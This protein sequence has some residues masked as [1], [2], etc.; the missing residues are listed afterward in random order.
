[1]PDRD[2]GNE[3]LSS[4]DLGSEDLGSEDLA[5]ERDPM[6]LLV[7]EFT[8]R[9]RAGEAVDVEEFAAA[10]PAHEA[11]LRGLLPMLQS[12]EQVKRERESSG[13]LVARVSLPEMHRLGDFRIV[14]EVGRGGMGVVFEAFQ[15]SLS[16]RVALKVM[17]QATLLTGNQLMRFQREAQVA[18]QLHHSNIVPVFG[19]G[20]TDGYHWY[21]MQFIEGR[22]LDQWRADEAAKDAAPTGTAAWRDRGRF[23]AR[24][25][26]QVAA[27]L[28]HAHVQGTLHR[29][30]KPA[31]LLLD[32]NDH[33]WVTDF[34]LAKALEAEGLTQSGDLLGTLQYMAPEQFAGL[35][36]A[37]S[38][39]YALGVTLYEL[40][41]LQSAFVGQS[42]S[43]LMAAIRDG[44]PASIRRLCPEA[45]AD[46][47]TIVEKS[48]ASDPGDRYVSADALEQ[49]LEAFLEDRPIAARRQSAMGQVVRWCRRNRAVAAL[50]AATL[51]AVVAAG[52]TGWAAYVV[53][54]DALSTAETANEQTRAQRHRAEANLRHALSAFEG[55]FDALVGRD[56]LLLFEADPDT[57]E[58]YV[59]VQRNVSDQDLALLAGMLEF[60]DN[61]AAQNAESQS[62][63]FETARAYRRVGVIHAR[64]GKLDEAA[65]AYDQALLRYRDVTDRDVTREL[66]AVHLEYG[67]LEQRRWN[68][69][70][71]GQR[72]GLALKLLDR[73]PGGG[74]AM[75]LR[76]ERAQAHFLIARNVRAPRRDGRRSR[77]DRGDRPG[78]GERPDRETRPDRLT[79][80]ERRAE[81]QKRLEASRRHLAHAQ[82]ILEGLPTAYRQKLDVRAFE[83]RCLLLASRFE[84]DSAAAARLGQEGIELLREVTADNPD[85]THVR[86]EL[87]ETLLDRVARARM[88]RSGDGDADRLTLMREARDHAERL[89]RDQP[90]RDHRSLRARVGADLGGELVR[91]ADRVDESEPAG[92]AAAAELRTEAEAEL[93]DATRDPELLPRRTLMAA[94]LLDAL[95][96]RSGRITEA[97]AE[98]DRVFPAVRRVFE[99]LRGE[100]WRWRPPGRGSGRSGPGGERSGPDG[101]R[102]GPRGD[103]PMRGGPPRDG[104]GGPGGREGRRGSGRRGSGRAPATRPSREFERRMRDLFESLPRPTG[105]GDGRSGP[106]GE[107]RGR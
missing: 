20:E 71:A 86:F 40:L 12:L 93:R 91:A 78:P 79:R 38:E 68:P 37:R 16:R 50:I 53:T 102:E 15:E 90:D 70:A 19:S 4:E 106:D 97:D 59:V 17:P 69:D 75:A 73:E 2:A 80:E 36:D 11:E 55:V 31:N 76:F 23:V 14:V 13:G 44:R 41:T 25:G 48:I 84:R 9:L 72:F 10:H 77:G 98:L 24:V 81:Q 74:D 85:A 32:E 58:E 6:D 92:A 107:R 52:I 60:Y 39:V 104:A 51:V 28:H 64:L 103:P 1:M 63:R 87:C 22:G 96:R 67:Q 88:R 94:G 43:E 35:Y 61:F 34:G 56:P 83:A 99:R 18:A 5:S 101:L 21:A 27:A 42:K 46:L 47:V 33:V 65:A 49:D 95:L 100:G 30:I 82:E 8:Q 26:A 54:S 62:L 105:A 57:G 7:E 45:P 89:V 66:A 29:D 3:E